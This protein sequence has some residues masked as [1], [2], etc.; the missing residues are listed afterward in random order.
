MS[1]AQQDPR[2]KSVE[3]FQFG[4]VQ[5]TCEVCG[6]LR[7]DWDIS[8]LTYPLVVFEGWGHRNLRYCNDSTECTQKAIKR[9]KTGRP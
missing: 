6:A 1:S 5:W 8:V 4:K 9:S 3:P 2:R 7:D